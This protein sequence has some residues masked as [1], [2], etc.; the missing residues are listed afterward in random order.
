MVKSDK[1]QTSARLGA[2]S[3]LLPTSFMDKE[4]VGVRWEK[5]TFRGRVE[6]INTSVENHTL[7]VVRIAYIKTHKKARPR[8]FSLGARRARSCWEEG[9]RV[10]IDSTMPRASRPVASRAALPSFVV[11]VQ[12]RRGTYRFEIGVSLVHSSIRADC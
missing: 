10:Y 1:S 5:T 11:A 4:E 6:A 7:G 8:R 9:A 12:H 2:R 3:L